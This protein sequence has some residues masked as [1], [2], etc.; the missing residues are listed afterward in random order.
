MR[1][2]DASGLAYR[3]GSF[4]LNPRD[5]ELR[6]HGVRIKLQDQPLQ[7]LLLLLEHS[8]QVVSREEI[9][10]RLWPPG[11][12]VDYDNAIN[13]AVRK[14]REALG[15]IS[16][17]PRFIETLPRRGYRFLCKPE[18]LSP[19]VRK[20]ESTV[21]ETVDAG[22]VGRVQ[23]R[24]G[25]HSIAAASGI[26]LIAV[27]A[28]FWLNRRPEYISSQLTPLP[29]T[30]AEGWELDPGFSPDGNQIVYAWDEMGNGSQFHLYVKVIGSGR[31]VRLTSGAGSDRSPVWSPD[32]RYIAFIRVLNDINAIY[33]IPALGGSERKLADGR[34]AST[35]SWSPDGKFL[36]TAEWSA[37]GMGP[38]SLHLIP[39]E[40]GEKIRLTSPDVRTSDQNPAFSPN[41][42]V[43]L[44]I[45]CDG[46]FRCALY[47][48]D[49]AS[50]YRPNGAPRM[51]RQEKGGIRGVAWTA[52][53]EE[54]V[55]TLSGDAAY[56]Y[57]LMRIRVKTGAQPQRLTFAGE[58]LDS[59]AVA[60]RG[61]RLAY[62]QR[63]W[64]ED[65]WQVQPDK[66][67]KP[68]VSSR[69]DE[70]SPQ[71]SPDGRRVVFASN[72]SGLMQIWVCDKDGTNPVQL[73]HFNAGH[74]GTPRW[75][76]DGRWIAFDRQLDEGWRI[77]VM[78]S[79]GG[80]P[81]RLTADS[82]A[83]EVIPS[84]SRDGKWIYYACNRT[85]SFQIWKALAQS[86]GGIRLTNNNGFV[87][88]ES[89]VN[90]SIYYT[91]ATNPSLWVLPVTGGK[92]KLV[93][94]SVCG[95]GFAVA[96]DGIYYLACS[97]GASSINFRRFATNQTEEIARL[98]EE[99]SG[100]GLTVSPDRQT[101]LFT[102]VARKGNNVMVVDKFR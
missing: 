85:G 28:V 55:Y 84:W 20:P 1:E 11:T 7:I 39:T 62:S 88:F 38:S 74:S 64:D 42:R 58:R 27:A 72:R 66:S 93:L 45:R 43:L 60:P 14:L 31:P 83:D 8:G 44:F 46:P 57:Q 54:A 65:V 90:Q 70:N 80:Q 56:N 49:L 73:T 89:R 24:R 10:S 98:T 52:D 67:P 50:D 86:G 9:H 34:F 41:G 53:G 75:S 51:L 102:V 4:E 100:M 48:L 35:L 18:D 3:F 6:K 95:R 69:R 16:E 37:W 17:T 25:V 77:F 40:S 63:L 26:V 97:D 19:S 12:H 79:D 61:D 32:G 101:F 29:L 76:P 5:G 22:S 36:V 81:R 87:A 96:E 2:T 71:Y 91:G 82:G 94:D 99:T 33:V 78:A 47:S 23:R 21:A 15:D 30:A 92:E 68:F 59:V 13:S